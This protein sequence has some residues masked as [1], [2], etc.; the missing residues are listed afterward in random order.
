M[1]IPLG[2]PDR[3]SPLLKASKEK[4]RLITEKICDVSFVPLTE[5]EVMRSNAVLTQIIFCPEELL[6][7]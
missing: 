1:V 7:V 3:A 5:I 2:L 4:G 6:P